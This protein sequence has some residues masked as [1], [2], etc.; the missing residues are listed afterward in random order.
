MFRE[1]SKPSHW[2]EM[3]GMTERDRP[4]RRIPCNVQSISYHIREVV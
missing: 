3:Q 1:S 2:G 4:S